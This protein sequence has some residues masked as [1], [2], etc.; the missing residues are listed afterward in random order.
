MGFFIIFGSAFEKNKRWSKHLLPPFG[1]E[2][3]TMEEVDDFYNAW[4][5]FESWREFTYEQLEELERAEDSWERRMIQTEL[6]RKNKGKRKEEV[7]RIRSLVDNAYASDP[8]IK[9][10]QK[11]EKLR[12]EAEKEKKR[13]EREAKKAEILAK[14]KAIEDAKRAEEEKKQAEIQRQKDLEKKNRD[15]LKK[16]I[17]NCRKALRKVVSDKLGE[18]SVVDT[19][20]NLICTQYEALQL[21]DFTEKMSKIDKADDFVKT[22]QNEFEA[23]KQSLK[24]DEQKEEEEKAKRIQAAKKEKEWSVQEIQILVKAANV[25]PAGTTKRWDKI[26]TYYNDHHAPEDINRTPKDCMAAIKM[27]STKAQDA[28][29]GAASSGDA[30]DA[31]SLFLTQRKHQNESK[32]LNGE[33]SEDYSK[34]HA[35]QTDEKAKNETKTNQSQAWTAV[36]QK[37]LEQ[38]LRTYPANYGKERWDKIAE[39]M[40]NRSKRE[41]MLRYKQ[42]VEQLKAKK[43]AAAKVGMKK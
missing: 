23:I 8:R 7:K 14:E 37:K 39:A 16:Q 9:R 12:K 30:D 3:S 43:Q 24:N 31:F 25:F 18:N 32:P 27:L 28:K 6:N 35:E 19:E 41:C 10:F 36:E 38:A 40:P 13:L 4:Y 33:I 20:I 29:G 21:N 2:N 1:D 17:K 5:D 26:S 11:E 34:K 15:K 42:I 22:V